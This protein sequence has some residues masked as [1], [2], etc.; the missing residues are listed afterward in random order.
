MVN[1]N[2]KQRHANTVTEITPQVDKQTTWTHFGTQLDVFYIKNGATWRTKCLVEGFETFHKIMY[3][4]Y[5]F[6]RHVVYDMLL[7]YNHCSHRESYISLKSPVK[8][9]FGRFMEST[10]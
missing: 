6:C 7:G 8:Q 3:Y 9:Y 2:A 1:I 10:C 4:T 5:V